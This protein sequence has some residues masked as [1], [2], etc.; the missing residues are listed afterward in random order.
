MTTRRFGVQ[1]DCKI[2]VAA[3]NLLQRSSAS[4]IAHW[5]KA[6]CSAAHASLANYPWLGIR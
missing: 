1:T 4:G 5:G 2:V 6:L 3:G